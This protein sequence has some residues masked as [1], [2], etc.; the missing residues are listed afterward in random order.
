M[1]GGDLHGIV[2]VK[3]LDASKKSQIQ[4]A[5]VSSVSPRY[6]GCT[7]TTTHFC[8]T[9]RI[10]SHMNGSSATDFTL[11]DIESS[12]GL[13]AALKHTETSVAVSW[14]GGGQVKPGRCSRRIVTQTEY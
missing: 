9:D 13:E 10:K 8:N 11:S 7:H 12:S 5:Y 6:P 1:E 4:T 14:S 2:S 3:V